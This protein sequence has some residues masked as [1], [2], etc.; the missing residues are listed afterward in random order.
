M[1]THNKRATIY[2]E[3]ELHHALRIKSAETERSISELVNEAIKLS[4]AEDRID[5]A[6]FEE[7]ANEPLLAFEN[8]LKSLK[9]NGKI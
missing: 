7:R 8:V 6:A 2:F 1:S 5:L 4:L 9:R 3:S